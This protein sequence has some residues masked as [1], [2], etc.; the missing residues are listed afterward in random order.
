MN[1]F[2]HEVPLKVNPCAYNG[3]VGKADDDQ[4]VNLYIRLTN[5]CNAACDF[6]EFRDNKDKTKFDFY[7]FFYAIQELNKRV[8]I[9]KI[10]FTG[11]EPTIEWKM[12]NRCLHEVKTINQKIFTVV[13]SNGMHMNHVNF[14][15]LDSYALSRH[16]I[17]IANN[18]V[19]KCDVI[20]DE[21]LAKLEESIKNKIHLSCNLSKMEIDSPDLMYQYI[22]HYSKLGFH[23]FGFVT[24]MAVNQFCK[25]N[26]VDFQK[27]KLEEMQNT[28]RV[29]TFNDGKAC[30]C[31]NYVTFDDEGD[32]NRWYARHYCDSTRAESTL[33]YD[34]DH[35]K[36]GFNG[37][38]ILI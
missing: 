10:S 37:D 7:K 19:F 29:C 22:N 32:L 15:Y 31:A 28:R 24:L 38:T 21:K 4:Y 17:G 13:N 34:L 2:G 25:E 14:E 20:S 26:K 11:G 16:G 9:N 6:C 36:I 5:H 1:I 35:L 18:A 27:L 8:R 23:D 3:K 12:L 30:C 33:V